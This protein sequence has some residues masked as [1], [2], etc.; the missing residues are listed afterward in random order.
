[1]SEMAATTMPENALRRTSSNRPL[2]VAGLSI[3]VLAVMLLSGL[4]GSLSPQVSVGPPPTHSS[5]TG[6]QGATPLVYQGAWTNRTTT[7]HPVGRFRE[8]LASGVNSGGTADV[9]M[10]GGYDGSELDDLWSYVSGTW[11]EISS[12]ATGT[13]RN[14]AGM[15]QIATASNCDVMFG[16]D[17]STSNV[18]SSQT[19]VYCST[20]G[21]FK[22]LYT[23]ATGSR[24]LDCSSSGGGTSC[25]SAVFLQN[26]VDDVHDDVDVMYG[27]WLG[28]Q[29]YSSDTWIFTYS[30]TS[31]GHWYEVSTSSGPSP[32]VA[33]AGAAY[34][35]ADA[36]V[37]LFGG[38]NCVAGVGCT[39]YSETCTYTNSSLWSCSSVAGPSARMAW[40]M[41]AEDDDSL[42]TEGVV[43]FS[44][45]NVNSVGLSGTWWYK[46]GT[47]TNETTTPTPA[48]RGWGA[49]TWDDGTTQVILF[50]GQDSANSA[51]YYDTWSW[52]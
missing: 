48:N 39:V 43:M 11:T 15:A 5:T 10:Y 47:W 24:H 41:F 49:M 42:S 12:A 46:G 37:V 36:E 33:Q 14:G 40:Q 23:N 38:E 34:D 4:T 45:A 51:Y 50:A 25:P 52:I 19:F 29:S 26:L 6:G 30:T 1:M 22:Q 9:L 3:A 16:G 2:I 8:S 17:T 13:A 7:T 21:V 31:G 32:A 20:T 27:G 44:G 18:L 35:P 28:P